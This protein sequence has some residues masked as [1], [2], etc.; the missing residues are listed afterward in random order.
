MLGNNL[1]IHILANKLTPLRIRLEKFLLDY[2]DGQFKNKSNY[3]ILNEALKL[4]EG[5]I[6]HV[7][8]IFE[9]IDKI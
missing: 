2:S 3:E 8:D 7:D 1:K 4:I 5:T 6:N 9:R